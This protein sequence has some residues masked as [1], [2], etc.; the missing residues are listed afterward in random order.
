M[1]LI[2]ILLGYLSLIS[3]LDERILFSNSD[4]VENINYINENN[5]KNLSYNVIE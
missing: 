2:K 3:E 5:S 4:R 1:N